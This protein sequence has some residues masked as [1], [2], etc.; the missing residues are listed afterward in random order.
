MERRVQQLWEEKKA[1]QVGEHAERE[2][3][4]CLSMFPYPSGKLH[5]GHVRNYTIGD[6]I[7]RYWRM[8]G[9]NVLQPMG[10][11]AFGLPAENAAIESDI[12]PA[13]WT[14]ANIGEMRSQL[15][16]LGLAIDWTRELATC[17]SDYY[18]WE[19]LLVSRLFEKGLVYRKTG[20]VNWDPVD[21]TV[22]ANEQVIDGRGWRSGV[23]VEQ[24]EIPM[25][26]MRITAYADEL[27]EELDR[28]DGWP[29]SVKTMQRKWIGRS[30]GLNIGFRI[31]GNSRTLRV[32]TTRPDTLMGTTYIALAARHPLVDEIAARN[33]EIAA[34]VTECGKTGTSESAQVRHAKLGMPLGVE[35]ENPVDGSSIPVWV[36]SYVLMDYGEGAVMGVPAHDQRDFEFAAEHGLPVRTVVR[37]PDD[38]PHD[39]TAAATGYG[40]TCNSGELDGLGFRQA[41]DRIEAK[42]APNG[43][44]KRE[45]QYR[46]R[47]WGFSRQRYWGCL[48]PVIH[49]PECGEMAVPE[50]DLPVELPTERSIRSQKDLAAIAKCRCPRCGGEAKRETDTMDTFVESSWYFARFASPD[51]T[52]GMVDRRAAYWLPVDQYIG[53]IEHAVLHLLYARFFHKM[54]RDTGML[55]EGLNAPEP[56]TRLLC[57]GMVLKDGSKMSKSTGNTVD[58]QELIDNYGADTARLFI[59]FAAPPEQRLEWSD[60]GVKGCHRF[61][62]RLWDFSCAAGGEDGVGNA[63]EVQAESLSS[64][65]KAFREMV[66]EIFHKADYDMTRYRLNNIPSAGMK[67]INHIEACRG[68]F[69]GDPQGQALLAEAISVLLRMLAPIVPHITQEL[70]ERF[71]FK[72]LVMDA[73]WPESRFDPARKSTLTLAVQVNGKV[74]GQ[75]SASPDD[76]EDTLRR[77]ALEHPDVARHIDNRQIRRIIAVKGRIVNLVV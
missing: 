13:E 27:L 58:P 22:L 3:F 12:H 63:G 29:E 10:W 40:I 74:R 67:I 15:Q 33:V 38:V 23:P 76:G 77:L 75:I 21:Q 2:K 47:D 56:F 17:T 8:R 46:L 16:R 62:Q 43:M 28:L 7:S 1:F 41:F 72:G 36:A 64:E 48:I 68:V 14:H 61:L 19:Q 69:M 59:V 42:L 57:Q 6:A 39:G 35:A 53:G 73:A 70:W 5:M 4:Y 52:T 51:C 24:R 11:D 32:F 34:F 65:G 44:A 37:D 9:R 31:K 71:G 60:N 45:I 18:R 54:M 55:P 25:Y 30:E 66:D 50:K 20:T 49:C 26:F